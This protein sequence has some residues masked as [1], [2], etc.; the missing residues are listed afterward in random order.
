MKHLFSAFQDFETRSAF[1]PST[2]M[3]TKKA[4]KQA[5]L[6]LSSSDS[7]NKLVLET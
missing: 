6:A 4:F 3:K 7:A 1:L 5:I 2:K